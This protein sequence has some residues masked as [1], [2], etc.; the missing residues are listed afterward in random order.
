MSIEKYVTTA[1]NNQSQFKQ[2]TRASNVGQ[3]SE[4]VQK[5]DAK[6]SEPRSVRGWKEFYED[7]QPGAIDRATDKTW[8]GM[9]EL[10][11]NLKKLTKEDVRQWTEDLIIDKTFN[12]LL[13][14]QQKVLEMVSKT[15]EYRLATPEEESKGIDGV[16][17]GEFVS[18]RPETYKHTLSAKQQNIDVRIIYYRSGKKKGE[19]ELV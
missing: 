18:V 10:I 9:Q 14:K 17:D 4:M 13:E 19:I 1:I 11:E 6:R 3:L 8:A 7:D 2:S 12:G 15:G 5:Y 16:V